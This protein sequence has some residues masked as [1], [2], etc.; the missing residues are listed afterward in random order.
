MKIEFLA[1]KADFLVKYVSFLP[2]WQKNNSIFRTEK[3]RFLKCGL[4]KT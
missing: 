2:F 3:H 1:E 4:D